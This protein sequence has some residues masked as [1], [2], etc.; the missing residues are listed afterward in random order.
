MY[1]E[2]F[3]LRE[4]PFAI[5]PDPRFV[6]L[7][8]R[9]RDALAHLLYGIGQGGSG[10]F[11]LLTG[12]VGT[13]KTTLSRLLLGQLPENTRVAL[14][15]NPRLTPTELLETICE[16]LK[17]DIE[18]RRG[19]A[20]ALIDALNAYL[21]EAYAQG[22]RVVLIVDEAQNL[23]IE[24]LEQIRLLTNL[25]TAT[26]KLLQIILIGQPELRQMIERP[27]LR[28]LSQRITARYHLTPLDAAETEEYVRHRLE[29]AG[30]RRMPF[31][32]LAL[33]ALHHRA[34]GI[35]RLI[36][37]IADRALLAAYAREIDTVG[38][39][40]V[41]LAARETLGGV[42]RRRIVALG[43]PLALA[44]AL[45]GAALFLPRG[46]VSAP[47]P[48]R[49][50]AEERAGTAPISL[51]ELGARL[52]R[53]DE[54]DAIAAWTRLLAR[55]QV[56]GEE[57]RILDAKRCPAA[58]APGLYCTRG[59]AS[60]G[61]LRA[62]RR[63]V[64]LRLQFEGAE[65]LALLLG[66]G[67]E[68]ARLELGT[69]SVELEI[70][71]LDRVWRGEFF[72]IWRGAPELPTSLRR[73]DHGPAV[74]WLAE[75]LETADGIRLGDFVGPLLYDAAFAE[76]VRRFQLAQGLTPDGI[77][78][79]ETLLALTAIPPGGPRLSRRVP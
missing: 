57:V 64:L 23:S 69:E 10:G 58:L 6:F 19:S 37:V 54:H 51:A 25:E 24:A 22:L 15:L 26:Q 39:S 33:R 50:D 48:P 52:A 40:L 46:P 78:G 76:R 16:E 30:C 38:E 74:S 13:G 17:L 43:V 45:V 12:E 53:L 75:A 34:G 14:V 42:P 1:L 71:E 35:P 18:G 55:W 7:S 73:G 77:A 49:P 79:P 68:R 70:A 2:H 9:H 31:T 8:E 47:E 59:S 28:Q 27:E 63:P 67:R 3:G 66:I 72:A 60:L 56:R 32:R 61:R 21:L 11:V 65:G 5:T 29:V 62:L 44:A 41:R 36:N 4:P 20:K